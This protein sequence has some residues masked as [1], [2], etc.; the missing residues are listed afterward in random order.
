MTDR[1]VINYLKQ[2]QDEYKITYTNNISS[3][4]GKTVRGFK[5]INVLIRNGQRRYE[6]GQK[7][8]ERVADLFDW[9][10]MADIL[11][12]EYIHGLRLKGVLPPEENHTVKI[13]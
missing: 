10:R 11:E 3:E 8:R 2:H 9:H 1:S 7:A 6:V 13:K 5:N 12:R 4:G